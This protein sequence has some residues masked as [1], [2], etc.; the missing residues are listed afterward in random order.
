LQ[1]ERISITLA[2]FNVRVSS[3]CDDVN[4]VAVTGQDAWQGLN[5]VFE[6]LVW[7]QQTEREQDRLSG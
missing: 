3:A 2:A 7:R 1:L 4:N 6:S 5:H